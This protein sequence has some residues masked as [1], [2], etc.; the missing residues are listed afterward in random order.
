MIA[1][2]L[3]SLGPEARHPRTSGRLIRFAATAWERWL[4]GGLLVWAFVLRLW[5]ATKRLTEG[6][7]PDDRFILDNVSRFLKEGSLR[8]AH[9]HYPGLGNLLQSLLLGLADALARWTG[10]GSQAI[11]RDWQFTP[12]AIFLGRSFQACLGV[13]SLYWTY[14]LGRRLLS[15]R[16]GLLAALALSSVPLHVRQSVVM[17]PDVLLLVCLLVAAEA[18]VVALASGHLR[19][20][21]A[22]GAAVGLA[23]ASKY[24]GIA[25]AMPIAV[26]A[27]PRARRE[28][29]VL[30]RLGAA[31]AASLLVFVLFNPFFFFMLG[32]LRHDFGHTL[33]DYQQSASLRGKGGVSH[34][35]AP[36]AA[37]S[38]LVEP[39]FFGLVTGVLG[40]TGLLVTSAWAWRRRDRGLALL[41]VFPL[42]YLGLYGAMT[43][44]AKTNNY[45]PVCPFIALG[46]AALVDEAGMRLRG[47]A[48]AVGAILMMIWCAWLVWRPMASVYEEMVPTT[49]DRAADVL[50]ERL[51]PLPNLRVLYQ[52]G[53]TESPVVL[54]TERGV[55]M[56]LQPD[57]LSRIAKPAL[58]LADAEI[59]TPAALADRTAVARA[60]DGQVVRL[61]PRLFRARGDPLILVLHPWSLQGDP[62]ELEAQRSVTAGKWTARL[63][64]GLQV[65]AVV[66]FEVIVD[67]DD[68]E[69]PDAVVAG[70]CRLE[71]GS[72]GRSGQRWLTE[73]VRLPQVPGEVTLTGL[74]VEPQRW[75]LL[76]WVR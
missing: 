10:H 29:A 74:N 14:R 65:P 67:P 51:S 59:F 36:R 72:G 39:T 5:F 50:R 71:L 3:T 56:L 6:R 20:F 47:R 75:R 30:A 21:L 19:D 61:T 33:E 76:L 35:E 22:L 4:L 41:I 49:A 2:E 53:G 45:L 31:A 9:M 18:T 7:F 66:S 15:P 28:P 48:A 34:F 69:A 44:Y 27:L 26:L 58:D 16:A 73:R 60:G 54:R 40:L 23:T 57:R 52:F 68:D 70:T 38:F 64:E 8:P 11:L 12:A 1:N 17:K 24:N 46:A 55:A 37:L 32:K 63:P 62:V 42:G 25:A 13:L 43:T